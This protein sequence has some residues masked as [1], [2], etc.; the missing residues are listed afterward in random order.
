M[1]TVQLLH[2][3]PD[4]TDHVDWLLEKT[5][6][7]EEDLI[8]LRLKTP[9]FGVENGGSTNGIR[10]KDHRRIYLEY[11]GPISGDRG[12]VTRVAAGEILKWECNGDEWWINVQWSSGENQT[13]RVAWHGSKPAIGGFCDVYV[14]ASWIS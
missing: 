12:F 1:R 7:K 3:L 5:G 14:S 2:V 9:L 13:I 11:E 8:S 6:C 4:G 10:L